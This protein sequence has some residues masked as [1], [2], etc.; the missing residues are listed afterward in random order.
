MA[1]GAHGGR[2]AWRPARKAAG[3]PKVTMRQLRHTYASPLIAA[4]ESVKVVSERLGHTDAAMTPN[5]YSH[6][7]PDSEDRTRR[8]IDGAFAAP[9]RDHADSERTDDAR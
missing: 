7:F 9:V 3:L 8:A 1:A 5:V 6:L 2:R 4:G